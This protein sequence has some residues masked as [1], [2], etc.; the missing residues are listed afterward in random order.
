[1]S[2]LPWAGW[3]LDE[4]RELQH[5]VLTVPQLH[6]FYEPAAVTA[7]LRSHRR[8]QAPHRTTVV[9]HNGPLTRA[10]QFRVASLAAPEGSALWGPSAAEL[11]GLKGYRDETVHIA[12]PP[13]QRRLPLPWVSTHWSTQLDP[14]DVH[15]TAQPRRLRLPRSLLDMASDTRDERRARAIVLAGAQQGLVTVPALTDALTRR[16][17]C[18]HHALLVE[19]FADIVGGIQS[20][21]E[22]EFD[23]IVVVCKLPPPSRQAIRR[24]PDG[25]YYLDA[26]WEQFGFGV[27]VDGAQHR[28][29]SHWDADLD[30]ASEIVAGGVRLLRFS[31]FSVRHR[32]Q[33]VGDLLLMAARTGGWQG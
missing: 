14:R 22:K 11:D 4:L 28:L 3:T 31:S 27:E 1:M 10:Q 5:D 16:G 29:V 13:G 8:W 25:R 26:Y 18:R 32:P 19:T 2:L 33:R 20:V 24:R 17:P 6:E 15:P 9:L 21:P 30:R 12:M 7:A 23:G